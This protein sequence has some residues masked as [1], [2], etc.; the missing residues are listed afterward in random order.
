[1]VL[2]GIGWEQLYETGLGLLAQPGH[3]EVMLFQL[4]KLY[5]RSDTPLL[6]H[7]RLTQPILSVAFTPTP[8]AP[9]ASASQSVTTVMLKL[10]FKSFLK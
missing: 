8:H 4:P 7:C 10:Y 2:V 5:T 3:F 1:M 9:F 6:Y